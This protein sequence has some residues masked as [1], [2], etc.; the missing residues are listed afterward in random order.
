M[1]SLRSR[2]AGGNRP[3]ETL[4]RQVRAYLRDKPSR[5][6]VWSL[7]GS[8]NHP[9][10]PMVLWRD[11]YGVVWSVVWRS[12]I[13]QLYAAVFGFRA[14]CFPAVLRSCASC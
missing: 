13:R 9:D 2:V 7:S 12:I 1:Y 6:L 3:K 8:R 5:D 11:V 14:A 10:S 4:A